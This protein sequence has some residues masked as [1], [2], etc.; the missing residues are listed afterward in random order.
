MFITKNP[1]NDREN[2]RQMFHDAWLKHRQNMELTGLEKQIA[3]VVEEHPEWETTPFDSQFEPD[4]GGYDS[5][6][7]MFRQICHDEVL[8]REESEIMMG[9]PRFA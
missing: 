4:F 7:D 9:Q 6:A 5:L 1:Q 2:N 3:S 8:H